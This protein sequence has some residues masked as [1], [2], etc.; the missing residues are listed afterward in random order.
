M[1]GKNNI[2]FARSVDAGADR[3]RAAGSC[4]VSASVGQT[5]PGRQCIG[6]GNVGGGR[7]GYGFGGGISDQ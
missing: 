3:S 2:V 1:D 6:G 5:G 7:G 4:S